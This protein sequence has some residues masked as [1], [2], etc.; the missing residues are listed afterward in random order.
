MRSK[1]RT[2]RSDIGWQMRAQGRTTTKVPRCSNNMHRIPPS[3]QVTPGLFLICC[4]FHF[5]YTCIYH[6][7]LYVNSWEW[8]HTVHHMSYTWTFVCGLPKEYRPTWPSR[9]FVQPNNLPISSRSMVTAHINNRGWLPRARSNTAHHRANRTA[10]HKGSW[11]S[12]LA[13]KGRNRTEA[14]KTKKTQLPAGS[15]G[16]GMWGKE[17]RRT[18]A[19]FWSKLIGTL[20]VNLK[21][22][23]RLSQPHLLGFK[24]P[25]THFGRLSL[26][27]TRYLIGGYTRV[28]T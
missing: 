2:Y 25:H 24:P 12:F 5:V 18:A 19:T 9:L 10:S 17:T 14:H 13:P 20:G 23:G 7:G 16:A 27:I 8:L 26:G 6:L 11:G 22:Q 1:I 21:T 4:F 28:C 15:T 3:Y